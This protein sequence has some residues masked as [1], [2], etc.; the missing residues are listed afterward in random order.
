MA[1][2]KDAVGVS[3]AFLFE[4]ILDLGFVEESRA[5]QVAQLFLGKA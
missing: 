1:E 5:L 3:E 2:V 4:G